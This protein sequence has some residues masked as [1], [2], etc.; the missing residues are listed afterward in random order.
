MLALLDPSEV[1]S[2]SAPIVQA[3]SQHE[4]KLG[5]L[6]FPQGMSGFDEFGNDEMDLLRQT[7][8]DLQQQVAM[9]QSENQKLRRGIVGKE[10]CVSMRI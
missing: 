6:Y 8:F 7:I 9:L 3:P 4:S 2:F 10:I 5:Q 1:E